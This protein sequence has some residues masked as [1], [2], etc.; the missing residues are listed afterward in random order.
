[1]TAAAEI[2]KIL[3]ERQI[4][5]MRAVAS[6]QSPNS[7]DATANTINQKG[8]QQRDHTPQRRPGQTE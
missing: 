7:H 1:M 5:K 8:R 4:E 2:A 6:S 3:L